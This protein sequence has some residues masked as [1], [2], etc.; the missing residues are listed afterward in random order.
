VAPLVSAVVSAAVAI[1]AWR[2]GALRASGALAASAVGTAILL[3]TGWPGGLVLVAFFAP[4]SAISR[5]WP[6]P[7]RTPEGKGDRRDAW[8][9]L[10]NGGPPALLATL[11][12]SPGGAMLTLAAGLAAAAADTWATAVGA[13]STTPPRH[14]LT[15]RVVPP[16]TSGGVTLLGT[17]GGAAGAAVVA[18]AALPALGGRAACLVFSLGLCG[19]FLDSALGAG[20]QGKFRCD[21][22]DAAS[23]LRTHRCGRPTTRIGG[24]SWLTNDGVNA[25]ATAAAS[26]AGWAAWGWC[27]SH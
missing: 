20:L 8:Q 7:G 25:L 18:G 22:C 26:L 11:A 27:C 16:G 9:V 17:A 3:A 4:S 12:A 15:G 5:V 19:M 6:A 10:A 1:L 14:L 2:A 24:V 23:E 13:H 21:H